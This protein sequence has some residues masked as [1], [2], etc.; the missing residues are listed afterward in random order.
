MITVKAPNAAPTAVAGYDQRVA[1]DETIFFD[2]SGS[3]DRDGT[4]EKYL[5]ERVDGTSSRMKLFTDPDDD[6]PTNYVLGEEARVSFTA[7]TLPSGAA[8]VTHVFN[9]VGGR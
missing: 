5:W 2:G 1:S 4:I 9:L 6:S 3:S 7:D 8:D